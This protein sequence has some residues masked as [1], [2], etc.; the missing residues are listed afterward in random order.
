M[1]CDEMITLS[2][3]KNAVV[4]NEIVWNRFDAKLPSGNVIFLTKYKIAVFGV[5]YGNVP[6]DMIGWMDI[7][8]IEQMISTKVDLPP[9]NAKVIIRTRFGAPII[10]HITCT[11]LYWHPFPKLPK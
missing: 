3:C 8:S 6:V 9:R 7:P 11:D 4:S 1:E 5:G 2:S 10:G